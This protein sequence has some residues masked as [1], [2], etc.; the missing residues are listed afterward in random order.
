[1]GGQSLRAPTGSTVNPATGA[2]DAIAAYN[3]MFQ[4]AG[5]YTAYYRARGQDGSS[6]SLFSPDGFA[7]DPDVNESLSSG[8]PYGWVTGEMFEISPANVGVPLELRMGKRESFA[9]FDALVLNLNPAMTPA[10]LDALFDPA[11]YAADFDDNGRVNGL[12]L[13]TWQS[14]YGMAGGAAREDGDANGDG[15]IDGADF[16]LWQRGL[17]AMNAPLPPANGAGAPVPEPAA[18]QLFALSGCIATVTALCIR[19]RTT[20]AILEE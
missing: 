8:G 13:A 20:L 18:A 3:V 4:T 6:D 12:D 15:A 17:G 5:T 7:V 10:A 1:L 19:K 2:H 14:G 9:D 16:L 11:L